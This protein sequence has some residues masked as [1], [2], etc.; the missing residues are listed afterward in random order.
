MSPLCVCR[1][2][3]Q[4]S[5]SKQTVA[6]V[7]STSSTSRLH[8][9]ALRCSILQLCS[10]LNSRCLVS[11]TSKEVLNKLKSET[12]EQTRLQPPTAARRTYLGV[13]NVLENR[14]L[15]VNKQTGG[16]SNHCHPLAVRT[17]TNSRTYLHMAFAPRSQDRLNHAKDQS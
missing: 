13:K 3:T 5:T 16:G 7:T 8:R 9:F 11:N 1:S 15:V 14:E 10:P 6:F 12:I 17:S 4:V 2:N